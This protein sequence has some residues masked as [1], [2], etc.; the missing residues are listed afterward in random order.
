MIDAELLKVI[1]STFLDSLFQ[2][3]GKQSQ[4]VDYDTPDYYALRFLKT[5]LA[6]FSAAKDMT[7]L[8]E[9]S[10]LL[11]DDNGK[12]RSFSEFRDLVAKASTEFNQRWLQTEYDTAFANAQMAR[13]WNDIQSSSFTSITIRTAG[14]ERVRDSHSRYEG[15]TRPKNDPIW[16]S[17]WPPFDWN[18]RCIAEEGFDLNQGAVDLKEIPKLFRNNPGVSGVAFDNSHPY[19]DRFKKASN[20]TAKAASSITYPTGAVIDKITYKEYGLKPLKSKTDL[21]VFE[22]ISSFED[23][24]RVFISPRRFKV[25]DAAIIVSSA[26]DKLKL[27]RSVAEKSSYYNYAIAVMNYDEHW[28]RSKSR[29]RYL[30]QYKNGVIVLESN[31]KGVVTSIEFVE[32]DKVNDLRNGILMTI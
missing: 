7:Q 14:D 26:G 30:R 24:W 10:K 17:F 8:A 29:S 20:S 4:F 13:S 25:E 1:Q 31:K 18:C 15:F 23:W 5:N 3:Y 32:Y 16:N 21:N 9:F 12:R 19:F 11:L 22:R 6:A 28:I 2:G 27:T